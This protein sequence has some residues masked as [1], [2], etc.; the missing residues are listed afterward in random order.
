MTDIYDEIEEMAL[1]LRTAIAERDLARRETHVL[2]SKHAQ[3]VAI[4]EAERDEAR[5]LLS[6]LEQGDNLEGVLDALER[7]DMR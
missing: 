2:H 6:E 5:Q 4:L 1:H 3:M 7:W